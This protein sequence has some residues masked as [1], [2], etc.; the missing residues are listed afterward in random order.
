VISIGGDND[1]SLRVWNPKT[2]ECSLHMQVG[3]CL[4]LRQLR[5][6]LQLD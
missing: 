4:V 2:A 6:Q 5:M 3:V 1:C